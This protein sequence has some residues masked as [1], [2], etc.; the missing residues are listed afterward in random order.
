MAIFFLLIALEIKREVYEGALSSW[1]RASLPV[2][3]AI[4]GMAAPALIFLQTVGWD[5]AEAKGWAIPAATDIAFALG[6][7][8]LFGKRV[9]AELKTFLLALAVVD[10]L[11]AIVIIALFYPGFPMWARPNQESMVGKGLICK[12]VASDGR[13]R[14]NPIDRGP[15]GGRAGLKQA[16]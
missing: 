3:A 11:G 6:V 2:Y 12:Q 5:S 13:R 10:D 4:G 9:P 15:I 8:S 7:L 14:A 1:K 16:C